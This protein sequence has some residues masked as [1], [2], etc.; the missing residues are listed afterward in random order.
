M[1]PKFRLSGLEVF[2]KRIKAPGLERLEELK[3]S[4]FPFAMGARFGGGFAAWR[5]LTSPADQCPKP[6]TLTLR[7][8]LGNS[9]G[10]SRDCCCHAFALPS[11][12]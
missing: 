2:Q 11:N 10:E 5:V 6:G 12:R 4:G 3:A 9:Y 8:L 1:A 7:K